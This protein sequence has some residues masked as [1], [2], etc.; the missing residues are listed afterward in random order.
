MKNG[1]LGL[2]VALG[3]SV[4]VGCAE[5]ESRN[6]KTA[7]V[8]GVVT[9]DGKPL[10]GVVVCFS[11]SSNHGGTGVTGADGSYKLGNGAEPGQNKICLASAADVEDKADVDDEE[12]DQGPI[13][14][15]TEE[16]EAPAGDLLFPKKY[17]DEDTSGLTFPVPEGGSTEA[18]F[19][20]TSE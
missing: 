6:V 12:P 3:L 18:N 1:K 7:D 14:E 19:E 8:S 15:G 20:L 10:E 16:G 4:V 5:P 9:L 17:A 13:D 2:L 11:F